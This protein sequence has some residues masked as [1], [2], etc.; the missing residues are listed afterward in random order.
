M[1]VYASTH[2]NWNGRELRLGNRVMAMIVPD[3]D[4]PGMYRIIM[5]SGHITDVVN[6]SRAKDAA[7][8]LA[9]AELNKREAA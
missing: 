5:P 6:L 4:W 2:L 9:L 8:T 3:A 7:V 1:R